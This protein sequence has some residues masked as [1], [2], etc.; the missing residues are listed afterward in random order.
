MTQD[1]I[2][3]LIKDGEK[4]KKVDELNLKFTELKNE[5]KGVI[6]RIEKLLI[7]KKL[8]KNFAGEIEDVIININKAIDDKNNDNIKKYAK[9]LKDFYNELLVIDN[10]IDNSV[11]KS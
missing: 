11:A 7:E 9:I 4:Y 2:N 8:E 1:E 3:T 10:N 6:V 5:A